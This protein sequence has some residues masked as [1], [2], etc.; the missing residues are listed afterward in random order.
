MKIKDVQ[1]MRSL[2]QN[3]LNEWSVKWSLSKMP[4]YKIARSNLKIIFYFYMK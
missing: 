2:I 3:G 1:L 4:K